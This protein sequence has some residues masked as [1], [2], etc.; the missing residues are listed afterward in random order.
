MV[1]TDPCDVC[2]HE[3]VKT[4]M[5]G[6]DPPYSVAHECPRC[7]YYPRLEREVREAIQGGAEVTMSFGPN[8]GVRI[9][10][11]GLAQ[12]I[13]DAVKARWPKPEKT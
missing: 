2:G 1:S 12:I 7:G 8:G 11:G 9:D 6:H 13:T 10:A 3:Y 4:G 5:E